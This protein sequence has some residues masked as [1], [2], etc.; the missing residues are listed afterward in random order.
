MTIIECPICGKECGREY[1][2]YHVPGG[3]W[4]QGFSEGIGENFIYGGVWHCS[5][6]CVNEAN[7][8]E[9]MEVRVMP[10]KIAIS[11]ASMYFTDPV[12]ITALAMDIDLTSQ[13]LAKPLVEVVLERDDCM[14]VQRCYTCGGPDTGWDDIVDEAKKLKGGA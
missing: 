6:D 1:P 9:R 10:S 13:T 12:T 2:D 11:V 14:V 5:K 7:R 4:D 3:S 8:I